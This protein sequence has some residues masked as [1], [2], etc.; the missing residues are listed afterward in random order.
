[1]IVLPKG[2]VVVK[3]KEKEVE[4]LIIGLEPEPI[5]TGEII[6]TSEELNHYQGAEIKFRANYSEP[7]KINGLD[8]L[9]L[10]DLDSSMYYLIVKN[11]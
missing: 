3:A 5:D 9:Y 1:M 2:A 8:L 4:S 10:R 11:R 6:F 7:I